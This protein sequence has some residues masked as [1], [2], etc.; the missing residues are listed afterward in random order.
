MTDKSCRSRR[1]RKFRRRRLLKEVEGN[2]RR[3]ITNCRLIYDDKML[4]PV[5]EIR[6]C[7]RLIAWMRKIR[8]LGGRLGKGW[9]KMYMA[10]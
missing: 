8:R 6:L 3:V 10:L 7:C 2:G 4:K 5:D 1:F 9:Y